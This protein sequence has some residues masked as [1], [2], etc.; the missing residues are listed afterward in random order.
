MTRR[1][2]QATSQNRVAPR[3]FAALT[4]AIATATAIAVSSLLVAGSA[5]A[6]NPIVFHSVNG[7]GS[8]PLGPWQLL[9][10]NIALDLWIMSGATLIVLAMAVTGWRLTR[11]EGA[12]LLGLY[13]GYLAFLVALA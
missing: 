13:G 7:D 4:L 3:P 11:P 5:M 2:A 12:V 6:V 10:S 9:G 1:T 8:D